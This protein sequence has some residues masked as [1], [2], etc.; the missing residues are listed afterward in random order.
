MNHAHELEIASDI[1]RQA[2]KDSQKMAINIDVK[3]LKEL[4]MSGSDE[5]IMEGLKSSK[6]LEEYFSQVSKEFS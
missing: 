1:L 4:V 2:M 3:S 6:E 5:E